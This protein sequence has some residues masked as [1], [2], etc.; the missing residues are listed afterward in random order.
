[1]RAVQGYLYIGTYAET[2]TSTIYKKNLEKSEYSD[3]IRFEWGLKV[4]FVHISHI[5]L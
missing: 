1:M 5:S 2:H 4:I 3:K